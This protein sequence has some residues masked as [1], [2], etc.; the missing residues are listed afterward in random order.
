MIGAQSRKAC[1]PALPTIDYG[2]SMHHSPILL[3][4]SYRI[5]ISAHQKPSVMRLYL[6][7]LLPLL[8]AVHPLHAQKKV[9]KKNQSAMMRDMEQP[10]EIS[11]YEL[12]LQMHEFYLWFSGKVEATADSIIMLSNDPQIDRN[13]L[14]WKMYAIPAAQKA[15]LIE[16]PFAA[17]I[18][19][20]TLSFQQTDFF[21]GGLG[22]DLFG[23]WQEMAVRTAIQLEETT[24]S[25]AGGLS[26]N[27]DFSRG[28][29][30]IRKFAA[31]N[32]ITSLHFERASTLRLMGE[33]LASE[34]L[35][36]GKTIANVNESINEL[37]TRLNYY[38]DQLPKQVRWQAQYMLYETLEQMDINA[39]VDSLTA[40]ATH[41]VDSLVALA[42]S[43]GDSLF[44]YIDRMTVLAESGPEL[45]DNQ[46]IALT[47]DLQQERA[48]LLAALRRERLETLELLSQERA[49]VLKQ[50]REERIA[51]L[52]QMEGILNRT[53][54]FS[55]QETE[56]IIDTLF[57]RSLILLVLGGG[58]F[59]LALWMI[60]RGR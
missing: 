14:Q 31:D 8:L 15:I 23:P 30:E 13:A 59:L 43:K 58:F 1:D 48:I 20:A 22:K 45:M 19:A 24:L 28:E 54:Q 11:A 9:K 53:L 36:L 51:S 52:E 33:V 4:L 60:L 42:E 32:P 21:E 10:I 25:I 37:G 39:N 3:I 41:K 16:D 5:F 2:L 49:I 12:N 38:I 29:T 47:K 34:S 57:W 6:F 55:F 17:L 50:L 56:G 18:D 27:R 40:L 35:G 26:E 7:L 46:R 44:E